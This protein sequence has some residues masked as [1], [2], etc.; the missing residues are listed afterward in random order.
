MNTYETTKFILER[1]KPKLIKG[2]IIIF[3]DYYNLPG[4]KNGEYK[5]MTEIFSE[6]EFKYIAFHSGQI[7]SVQIIN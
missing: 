6:S 3:D 1:I 5:A 7:V 2:A 4:W